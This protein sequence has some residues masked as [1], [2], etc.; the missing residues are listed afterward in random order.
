MEE[1]QLLASLLVVSPSPPPPPS[2]SNYQPISSSFFRYTFTT[3]ALALPN[4]QKS[5]PAKSPHALWL[6][7]LAF[8]EIAVP[9]THTAAGLQV[10]DLKNSIKMQSSVVEQK[11]GHELKMS[12]LTGK[13]CYD[14]V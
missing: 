7:R 10:L 5:Q 12:L 13:F 14:Y 3:V 2:L 6:V 11:F 1:E 4:Q 8:K 9:P